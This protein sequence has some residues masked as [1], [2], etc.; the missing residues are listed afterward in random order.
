LQ[1]VWH[2]RPIRVASRHGAI[3]RPCRPR[4][5]REAFL[6]SFYS[7]WHAYRAWRTVSSPS[8]FLSQMLQNP[9]DS[10]C[11]CLQVRRLFSFMTQSDL[12]ILYR[13]LSETRSSRIYRPARMGCPAS[14][15]GP[16]ISVDHSV[17]SPSWEIVYYLQEACPTRN[18]LH[19]QVPGGNRNKDSGARGNQRGS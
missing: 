15:L 9:T 4:V 12:G 6:P 19:Q 5:D 10:C 17:L 18:V 7:D 14:R 1:R 11:R 16:S 8:T 13:H 3:E 2:A